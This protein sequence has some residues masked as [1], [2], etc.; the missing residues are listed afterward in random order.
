MMS[1]R[2]VKAVRGHHRVEENAL[3]GHFGISKDMQVEF[4]VLA[5]FL[6]LFVAEYRG[7]LFANHFNIE[8]LLTHR[9]LDGEIE[10]LVFF[11]AKTHACELGAHRGNGRG[12]RI[13]SKQFLFADG[14]EK[15]FELRGSI[16]K[17]IMMFDVFNR[18]RSVNRAQFRILVR[19]TSG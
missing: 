10:G 11:P 8:M 5:D 12:L 3:D 7:Q 6:D 19:I 4:D 13:Y 16:E 2:G 18:C 15:F 9:G 1:S 14:L 17:L